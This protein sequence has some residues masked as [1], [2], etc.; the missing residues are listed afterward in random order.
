MIIQKQFKDG[1]EDARKIISRLDRSIR[2]F[3]LYDAA[4]E[5]LSWDEETLA[6]LYSD[7]YL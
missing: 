4:M 1:T 3:G 7:Y 5:G 6:K 2:R